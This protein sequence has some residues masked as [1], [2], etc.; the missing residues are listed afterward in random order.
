MAGT[1]QP[2]DGLG[3]LSAGVSK[4]PEA[5]T[6]SRPLAVPYCRG[7]RREDAYFVLAMMPSVAVNWPEAVSPVS[8]G[9]MP[10]KPGGE[11]SMLAVS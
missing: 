4:R 9:K 7:S 6:R 1:R 11:L 10:L 5:I 3:R 2:R 8:F